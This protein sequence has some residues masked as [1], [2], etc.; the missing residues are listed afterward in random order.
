VSDE[1][2]V[3]DVE[4]ALE[5]QQVDAPVAASTRDNPLRYSVLKEMKKSAEH[6]RA[7]ALRQSDGP[8]LAM[9]L[10]SG[11]HA[12]TFGTPEVVVFEGKQRRGKEWTA[13]EKEHPGKVILNKKE[14]AK[15]KGMADSIKS[16]PVAS[17]VLFAKDSILE[18]RIDWEWNGRKWRST[19]DM[20]SF[21]TCG[22]LKTSRCADPDWF[23][24]DALRMSYHVQQAIY[25]R[26]IHQLTGVKPRDIYIFVV[27]SVYPYVVTPFQLS[28]RSLEHGDMLAQRWHEEF[29]RCE[30]TGKWPGYTDGIAELDVYEI[31]DES[32]MA[33]ARVM[34]NDNGERAN[35]AF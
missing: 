31:E 18:Q 32:E 9:R 1:S 10:G 27:E 34:A 4:A 11:C 23:W 13:F 28:E 25:R 21:R 17:R 16:H 7:A 35:V 19:P 3:D 12:L 5:E 24:R 30:E 14:F 29:L 15:A 2:E 6:A 22:E 8:S 20:R 33:V 26:A